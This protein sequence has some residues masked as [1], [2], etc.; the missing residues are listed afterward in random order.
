M[1][2]KYVGVQLPEAAGQRLP[3]KLSKPS[4][5]PPIRPETGTICAGGVHLADFGL[6]RVIIRRPSLTT[7][8]RTTYCPPRLLVAN[9]E[10]RYLA[11]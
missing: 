2:G 8:R 9:L 7:M 1:T 10:Q 6:E 11:Q 4:V 3:K 5:G